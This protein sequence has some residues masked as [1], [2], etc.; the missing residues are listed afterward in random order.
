MPKKTSNYTA[1]QRREA[2]ASEGAMQME[3]PSAASAAT[4]SE[5]PQLELDSAL[6]EAKAELV[7]RPAAVLSQ[8]AA[9]VAQPQAAA[10][11]ASSVKDHLQ[12]LEMAI[13]GEVSLANFLT[14]AAGLES[15]IGIEKVA[16]A[17]LRARLGAIEREAGV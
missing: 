17:S 13:V 7:A 15:V 5:E 11:A 14:R 12:R 1:E 4:D 6:A 16:G 9:A 8:P 10:Q 2:P 3:P